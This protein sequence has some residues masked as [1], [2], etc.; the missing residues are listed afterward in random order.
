LPKIIKK[1]KNKKYGYFLFVLSSIAFTLQLI[2]SVY[3]QNKLNWV[4]KFENPGHEYPLTIFADS[5]DN[6]Y[7]SGRLSNSIDFDPSPVSVVNL[8][9]ADGMYIAK[10]NS[11]GQYIWVKGIVPTSGGE[12]F[13]SSAVFSNNIIHVLGYF[14]DGTMDFDPSTAVHSLTAPANLRVYFIAQYDSDGDFI[15]VDQLF[16][17]IKDYTYKSILIIDDTGNLVVAG[18]FRDTVDFDPSPAIENRVA[19]GTTDFFIAKYSNTGNFIWV[20][21]IG[22]SGGGNPEGSIGDMVVD[23]QFNIYVTGYYVNTVDLDPSPVSSALFTGGDAFGDVFIAKYDSIGNYLWGYSFGN[24]GPLERGNAIKLD[25]TGNVYFIGNYWGTVDVDPSPTSYVPLLG[26]IGNPGFLIKYDPNGNYIFSNPICSNINVNTSTSGAVYLTDLLVTD[27]NDIY[28][29]GSFNGDSIALDWNAGQQNWLRN[30]DYDLFLVHYDSSLN[31]KHAFKSEGSGDIYGGRLF[32]NSSGNIVLAESFRY[33]EDFDPSNGVYNLTASSFNNWD[34]FFASYCFAPYAA[35]LITGDS[36]VCRMQINVPYQI[37]SLEGADSYNWQYSGAGV[38]F[39]N[40]DNIAYLNFSNSATSGILT[41]YGVN[42]CDNGEISDSFPITVLPMVSPDATLAINGP[43]EFCFG[44]STLLVI[45][46]NTPGVTFQWLNGNMLLPGETSSSLKVFDSGI[47][48]VIVTAPNSCEQVPLSIPIKVN[49]LPVIT[50]SNDTLFS[51]FPVGNQWFL[52]G[53]SIAGAINSFY[54]AVD[55]GIYTIH[56]DNISPCPDVSLPF[57]YNSI[58]KNPVPVFKVY[59]NPST[60]VF[61]VEYKMINFCKLTISILDIYGR[62]ILRTR[63]LNGEY[64]KQ[65]DLSSFAKGFYFISVTGD[66]ISSTQKV[67]LR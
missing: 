60:G 46:S 34:V 47:Y 30:A 2:P 65:I 19:E 54:V 18:S 53:T 14:Y 17:T 22:G 51:N 41:V 57:T 9:T 44:D 5:S 15:R 62:E 3:A 7:I 52:N 56:V 64:Q 36:T 32:K 29:T 42:A 50:Q 48:T 38:N 66:Q 11:L 58:Q 1:M 13:S 10:Y 21:N 33:T 55:P 27:E 26:S 37:S 35:G 6:I 16:S 40:G 63:I 31:V 24:I 23:D 12:V 20:Q 43:D 4:Q 8:S 25:K 39:T 28:I 59:P 67:I 45:S 49:H 61:I